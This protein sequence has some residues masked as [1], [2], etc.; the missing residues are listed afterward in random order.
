[1]RSG[2]R[3]QLRYQPESEVIVTE[4][5][6]T[7]RREGMITCESG[8]KYH[9]LFLKR[10]VFSWPRSAPRWFCGS[11]AARAAPRFPPSQ[12]CPVLRSFLLL[13]CWSLIAANPNT[14]PGA[15]AIAMRLGNSTS[16]AARIGGDRHRAIRR[17]ASRGD[18]YV[19]AGRKVSRLA[20]SVAFKLVL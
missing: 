8:G 4:Q 15:L 20:Q 17:A 3:I 7:E 19:R 1:M 18:D 5:S 10:L 16:I 9:D 11:A 14:T 12:K 13:R 6:D 2:L